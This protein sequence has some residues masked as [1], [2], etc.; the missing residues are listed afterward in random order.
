MA[1]KNTPWLPVNAGQI[2]NYRHGTRLALAVDTRPSHSNT[3]TTDRH[4]AISL[5][6]RQCLGRIPRTVWL[7]NHRE[8]HDVQSLPPPGWVSMRRK[9]NTEIPS[10]GNTQTNPSS[11]AHTAHIDA[12]GTLV[13]NVTWDRFL[14]RP[15]MCHRA[16]QGLVEVDLGTR[17]GSPLPA[18]I[19]ARVKERHPNVAHSDTVLSQEAFSVPVPRIFRMSRA[20]LDR[21][22]SC[23]AVSWWLLI[24]WII[25][26]QKTLSWQC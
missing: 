11:K 8:Y 20:V 17:G 21:L 25:K 22:F 13:V 1:Y 7:M 10:E 18:S 14:S 19:P 15:P 5:V 23:P 16:L 12:G 24:M 4:T 3:S 6:S 26:E 9:D 2:T